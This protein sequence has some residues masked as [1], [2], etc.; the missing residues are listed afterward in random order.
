MT[1]EEQDRVDAVIGGSGQRPHLSDIITPACASEV[2]G[3]AE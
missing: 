1:A 3:I 2:E